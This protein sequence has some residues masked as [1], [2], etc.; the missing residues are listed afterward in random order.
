MHD[1]R[2][3]I[4]AALQLQ[5][6]QH[7]AKIQTLERVRLN[8]DFLETTGPLCWSSCEFED[9]MA[10]YRRAAKQILSVLRAARPAAVPVLE[11]LVH[12]HNSSY[13]ARVRFLRPRRP[14]MDADVEEE[15]V[16]AVLEYRLEWCAARLFFCALALL[17]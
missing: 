8:L 7:L 12:S 9:W 2:P 6:A 11:M 10:L 15:S 16:Q 3:P 4:L 1:A 17:S 13:W 5:I 14:D